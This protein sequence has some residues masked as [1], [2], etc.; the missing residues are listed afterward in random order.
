M[1]RLCDEVLQLIFYEL[2][3]PTA[4][5]LTSK[6]FH[7][8]SQD[9]YVRAHYF[10]TRYG[11][12]QAMY[13][14]F[15]RGKLLT[16]RVLDILLASGARLSRYLIQIAIH[17]YFH[18]Q[19]HFIKT[20]WVRNVSFRVF[21]YILTLAEKLYGEIPRGKQED[22]GYIFSSFLKE[23]RYPPQMKFVAWEDVRDILEKYHF[24]P[25]CNKDPIMAQFP[26]ALAIEPR[27]LPYAKANGFYMDSKYRDLVIRKMFER[28][29]PS[30][31][32]RAEDIAHNVRELCRL[33]PTIFVS[34]TVAAEIC[35]EAKVN[36]TGYAALKQL[37][38]SGD[39]RFE[40]STLV[41]DLLKTFVHTRSITNPLTVEILHHLY[42]D[43]PSTNPTVRLVILITVFISSENLHVTPANTHSKLETLH[44]TPMTRRDVFSILVSPFVERYQVLLEYARREVVM[45]EGKGMGPKEIRELV[46]EVVCRCLEI[47]CKGKLLKKLYDGFPSIQENVMR[48]VLENHQLSL[49]DLPAWDVPEEADTCTRF[50][51]KLCRDF[52]RF[53]LPPE[54][55]PWEDFHLDG[56]EEDIVS[57]ALPDSG[58]STSAVEASILGDMDTG[59]DDRAPLEPRPREGGYDSEL[60]SITQESLTTMIRHDE[61]TPPRSRRRIYYSLG[62]NSDSSGKL[63]YPHDA[64]HVGRWAKS[65]FG[66]KSSIMAIF[67]TH[68]IL[69]DNSHMLHQYL[70]SSESGQADSIS[71][72]I[73]VTF[74][75][76]Q[77]L[78][79]LGRAPPVYLFR[80]IELGAEF[81][82]DEDDYIAKTDA[83]RRMLRSKIKTE[84]PSSS[85]CS[86]GPPCSEASSSYSAVMKEDFESPSSSRGKKRPRR[87]AAAVRS[88]AVPDSDDEAIMEVDELLPMD[89]KCQ[90]QS[91]ETS[92]QLWL[93][94]LG[95]LCKQEQRKHKEVKRR[96]EMAEPGAKIR[97]AKTDFLKVVPVHLRN[98]RKLEEEKR[99]KLYGVEYPVEEYTDEDDEEYLHRSNGRTKRRKITTRTA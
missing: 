69:N 59:T 85:S 29:T 55:H 13:F 80:E 8:F 77:L 72:H 25:F 52:L 74:K 49:E 19:A 46:Q 65:Q 4:L 64:L 23:S 18:T 41:E 30:N 76:F 28:L 35:M 68:A 61:V 90:G 92:L 56:G 24:I 36:D 11:H 96:A 32:T 93:K 47:A 71:R 45:K 26:L 73:P 51:A 67:M 70:V 75:H 14:A 37:D 15:G 5:T 9:P 63:H 91:P 21:I 94:N 16:E 50:E 98:L 81:F 6:R 39:L 89:R 44:L 40:L 10:L 62:S 88:Y 27:L 97:Q 86:M 20:P 82:V 79:K 66:Q 48:Y 33:D 53:L 34:R 57:E 43:F 42:A 78:A 2:P 83:A 12:I 95:D 60:G 1:N 7:T 84:S 99:I 58:L 3:D 31:E 87:S 54:H 38:Q 22:D 17:H